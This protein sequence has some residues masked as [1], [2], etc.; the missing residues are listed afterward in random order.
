MRPTVPPAD[1]PSMLAKGIAKLKGLGGDRP[2]QP[3]ADPRAAAGPTAPLAGTAANGGAVLAGP[4]AW[5]W[6]GYGSV[7]PG[8]NP[9]APTGQYPRGSANWYAVT[10]ATPGA[11][12]VPVVGPYRATPGGEPPAYAQ[13]PAGYPGPAVAGPMPLPSTPRVGAVEEPVRST[14][15]PPIAAPRAAVGVPTLTP[16]PGLGSELPT[17]PAKPPEPLAAVPA[18]KPADPEP[19]PTPAP[20]PAVATMPVSAPAAPAPPADDVRW[21]PGPAK[22]ATPPAGENWAPASPG[23]A[24]TARLPVARGQSPDADP[25]AD[26]IRAVCR[27]RADAVEIRRTGPT[28][29]AVAF[30]ARSAADAKGLV[31]DIS[32]R[33]ELGPYRIDFAVESFA[34][35]SSSSPAAPSTTRPT[36]STANPA[37]CGSPAARWSPRRPTHRPP[38]AFTTC[39][40]WW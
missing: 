1:E 40:V 34:C 31:D 29:L 32:R 11:F 10:G 15:P 18:A 12:P 33:P 8:A 26:L 2:P 16:P 9:H 27:G 5:R 28:A 30:E 35:H 6:Y 36:A 20:L 39:P 38:P 37:T 14:P 22:P 25:L 7:T 19:V 13:T 17:G 24:D 21:Q 23:A 3:V 4:P